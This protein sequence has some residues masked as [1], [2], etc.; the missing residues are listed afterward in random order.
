MPDKKV[1]TPLGV[2]IIS[3]LY[4]LVGVLAFL[5]GILL[6]AGSFPA[7]EKVWET[8]L[9]YN[10]L[11]WLIVLEGIIFTPLGIFIFFVG[12]GLQ[13]GKNWARI[14]TIIVSIL[15][16]LFADYLLSEL[17]IFRVIIEKIISLA[18]NIVIPAY[19]FFNQTAKEFFNN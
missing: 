5:F 17:M 8:I 6:I 16:F 11:P 9:G 10:I 13:K 2:K 7:G 18:I 14:M 1:E 15:G 19:L 4:L 12:R 3:V